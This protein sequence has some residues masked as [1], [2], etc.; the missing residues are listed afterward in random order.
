M[1]IGSLTAC[2]FG[3]HVRSRDYHNIL[4]CLSLEEKNAVLKDLWQQHTDEMLVLEGNIFTVCGRQCTMEFQ[5]SADM[6]WQSWANNELNQAAIFPSPYANV[7]LSSLST[8]NGS[9][10][11]KDNSTWTP[12]TKSVREKH[13][14][15]VSTFQKS[16]SGYC[17]KLV[18][19][20]M[21]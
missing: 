17:R 20:Y 19:T 1:S 5:P 12:Y 8:I 14:E 9:I 10:G 15:K 21:F 2:N 16:L 13:A 7:S 11:E 3:E 6:S 18:L 4:H